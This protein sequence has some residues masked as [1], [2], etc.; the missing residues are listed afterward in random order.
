MRYWSSFP[1]S[2]RHPGPIKIGGVRQVAILVG[3]GAI[4]TVMESPGKSALESA[5]RTAYLVVQAE[6]PKRN[7]VMASISG[8]HGCMA[9]PPSGTS[10]A[11]AKVLCDLLEVRITRF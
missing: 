6:A 10:A 7:F 4:V 1:I 8:A 9:V 5:R 2:W 11:A 3:E